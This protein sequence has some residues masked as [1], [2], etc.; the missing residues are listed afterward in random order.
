MLVSVCAKAA[1]ND[2]RVHVSI[3]YK[4]SFGLSERCMG[5]RTT[6]KDGDMYGNTFSVS[7]LY[8]INRMFTAGVGIA[9]C[10]YE[11]NPGAV[12]VFATFRYRPFEV[13]FTKELY[14]FTS[15]GYGIPAGDDDTLSSGFM[16]DLGVGWQKMFRR[17]FGINVQLG[18]GFHQFRQ[19]NNYIW[20]DGTD[21]V[22]SVK[23]STGRNSLFV[24]FGLVF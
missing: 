14:A 20:A 17:H 18:Y 10:A 15:L 7:V 16:A 21:M 22:Y 8:D 11:P 19:N 12:P 23:A 1:D 9:A 3:D 2:N 13:G 6:N 24:G 5:V 4:H